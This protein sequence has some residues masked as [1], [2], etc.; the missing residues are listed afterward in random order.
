MRVA[1]HVISLVSNR[2]PRR[3]GFHGRP[4]DGVEG[5]GRLGRV[6]L[7]RDAQ[8]SHDCDVFMGSGAAVVIAGPCAC[9]GAEAFVR[10]GG[11]LSRYT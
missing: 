7:V 8:V 3:L 2:R 9:A 1:R 6:L 5:L 10:V 4:V 11:C